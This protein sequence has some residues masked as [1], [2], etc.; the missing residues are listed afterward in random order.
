M[1]ISSPI[2]APC[3]DMQGCVNFDP[4]LSIKR[5]H[6]VAALRRSLF[7]RKSN[8]KSEKQ[9]PKRFNQSSTMTPEQMSFHGVTA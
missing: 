3:D 4:N 2:H 8:Q 6:Q 7:A 5:G 1:S 9:T